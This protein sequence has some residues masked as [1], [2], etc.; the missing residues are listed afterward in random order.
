MVMANSGIAATP[1]SHTRSLD[2]EIRQTTRV[3]DLD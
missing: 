3:I 2:A 1:F